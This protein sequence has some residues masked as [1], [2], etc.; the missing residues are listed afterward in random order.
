[1]GK[2]ASYEKFFLGRVACGLEGLGERMSQEDIEKL[3]SQGLK[4]SDEFKNRIKDALTFAYSRDVNEY[5]KNPM[6]GDSSAL[7][8]DSA[9]RLYN[10]RETL[11]RDIFVEWYGRSK[12]PGFFNIIKKLIGK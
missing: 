8:N 6:P 4:C 11:L 1:L 10:G 12:K 3:L 2:T 7:W 5:N 9:N